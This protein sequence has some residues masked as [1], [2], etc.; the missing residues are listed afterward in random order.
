MKTQVKK[1]HTPLKTEVKKETAQ[2]K[3]EAKKESA[4]VKTEVKK[5]PSMRIGAWK[6]TTYMCTP[7]PLG[8]RFCPVPCA[9]PYA[10]Y[11]K[12]MMDIGAGF[13]SRAMAAAV[14]LLAGPH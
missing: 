4:Q 1:E 5:E 6:C 8:G 12:S 2:V 7:T 9:R 11:D 10:Q 14:P 13:L 3:T